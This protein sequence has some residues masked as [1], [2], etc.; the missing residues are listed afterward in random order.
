MLKVLER[1]KCVTKEF[2]TGSV[3]KAH[4]FQE[5][6]TIIRHIQRITDAFIS[7]NVLTRPIRLNTPQS[8]NISVVVEVPPAVS[9]VS[10]LR[11]VPLVIFCTW[12]APLLKAFASARRFPIRRLYLFLLRWRSTPSFIL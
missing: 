5:E 2:K 4:Y 1:A 3:V 10:Q 7:A 12:S 6:L 9:E 11:R 8:M